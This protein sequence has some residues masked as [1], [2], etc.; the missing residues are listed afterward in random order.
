MRLSV[1]AIALFTS[2]FSEAEADYLDYHFEV[3]CD[4]QNNRAEILPYA[5]SNMLV[6]SPASHDCELA[7]GRTIRTKMGLGPVYPYGNG[8]GDPSKWLSVWVDKVRVLSQIPFGC[9]D[10]GPCSIRIIVTAKDLTVCRREPP[11][12]LTQEEQP[13]ELKER[14]ELTP[15]DMLLTERDSLEFPSSNERARPPAGSLATLFAKDDQFCAQF[16]L[17]PI[18]RGRNIDN[19]A[20]RIGLPSDAQPVEATGSSP[21][22]YSGSYQQYDFDIDNDGKKEIVIG[23]HARTHARDGDIYF[24]YADE[25]IP[26]PR[27]DTAGYTQS[28]L[29]YAEAAK[30]IFPQ[31]WSEPVGNEDQSIQYY[32]D[33]GEY[34]VKNAGAPWWDGNDTPQFSFRYWYLWPFRYKQ[35]TYFLSW[36]QEAH[37]RHWYTILRPETNHQI[38]EMCVFQ[39]VQMRY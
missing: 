7:S 15:N 25:K 20:P 36:S 33:R 22:E 30:Q 8:G 1:A 5:V 12:V 34:S 11:D 2:I 27:V 18:P 31:D 9:D 6:Y 32:L 29:A 3:R 24:V 23:L 10:E 37:Q 16:P 26:D 4:S 38:T 17:L 21:Y 39:T 28:E 13:D 14:C 35:S 19:I